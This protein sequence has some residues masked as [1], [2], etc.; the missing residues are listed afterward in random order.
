MPKR[1]EKRVHGGEKKGQE[2][3]ECEND[4]ENECEDD[5][6][7]EAENGDKNLMRKMHFS[8]FALQALVILVLPA[9]VLQSI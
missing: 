5:G 3:G 7:N 6:N 2:V 4:C 8:M 1:D 9:R